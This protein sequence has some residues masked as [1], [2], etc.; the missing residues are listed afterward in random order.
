MVLEPPAS[1]KPWPSPALAP[2]CAS[3]PSLHT[4]CANTGYVQPASSAVEAQ[5][6]PKRQRSV[7]AP[8]GIKAAS[9]TLSI[10]SQIANEAGEPSR[11]S[12]RRKNGWNASQFHDFP[13]TVMACAGRLGKPCQEKPNTK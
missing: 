4:Q 3:H 8:K 11:A 10:C 2:S 5:A 13:P 6:A 7:A 1:T 9:P 12:P